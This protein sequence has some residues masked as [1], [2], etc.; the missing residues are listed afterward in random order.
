MAVRV[1]TDLLLRAMPTSDDFTN[2]EPAG[3]QGNKLKIN[4]C[5]HMSPYW[6]NVG[7]PSRI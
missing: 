5:T 2:P 4:P 1:D 6:I 7:E 3:G